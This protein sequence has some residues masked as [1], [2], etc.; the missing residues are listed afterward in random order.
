MW[1]AKYLEMETGSIET[2]YILNYWIS[3]INH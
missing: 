1:T 2:S 3:L